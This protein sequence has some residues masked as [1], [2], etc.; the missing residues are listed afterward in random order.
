VKLQIPM[1]I[2]QHRRTVGWTG[3]IEV[4]QAG[5]FGVR[6]GTVLQDDFVFKRF[7]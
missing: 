4:R 1:A 7:V 6:A 3:E 2:S 5:H